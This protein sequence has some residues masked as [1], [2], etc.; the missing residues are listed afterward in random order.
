MHHKLSS[1]K[2][3]KPPLYIRAAAKL[4]KSYPR[5]DSTLCL[6]FF[7]WCF[8]C[9]N[10]RSCWSC[11]FCNLSFFL[12]FVLQISFA[13]F[14]DLDFLTINFL[15]IQGL[16]LILTTN[17]AYATTVIRFFADTSSAMCFRH[18]LLLSCI[19]FFSRSFCCFVSRFLGRSFLCRSFFL[20]R[21]GTFCF[22]SF[23]GSFSIL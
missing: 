16:N 9:W 15:F 22:S 13:V 11:R 8:C 23:L 17:W 18:G 2:K 10:F 14:T 5:K 6:R 20:G 3:I 19:G 4:Q 7:F 1:L 12:S 21:S